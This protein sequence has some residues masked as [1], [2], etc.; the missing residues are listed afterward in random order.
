MPEDQLVWPSVLR[1]VSR[2]QSGSRDLFHLQQRT[3][4]AHAS[5]TTSGQQELGDLT[6]N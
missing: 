1:G 2:V 6:L 5:S 4:E 3:R